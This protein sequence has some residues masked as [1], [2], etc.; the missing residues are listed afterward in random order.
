M[1][2]RLVFALKK[3]SQPKKPRLL[4]VELQIQ[5]RRRCWRKNR[6]KMV[7]KSLP[8]RD[9]SISTTSSRGMKWLLLCVDV[10]DARSPGSSERL[11]LEVVRL[12][13]AGLHG[14]QRVYGRF[15]HF[16]L[17]HL[18]RAQGGELRADMGHRRKQATPNASMCNNE[19]RER[20]GKCAEEDESDPRSAGKK[21]W[22]F[23][24]KRAEKRRRAGKTPELRERDPE[25]WGRSVLSV[26]LCRGCQGW[27]IRQQPSVCAFF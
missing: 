17:H 20:S 13:A 25:D 26:R 8:K 16:D 12:G 9:V 18:L 3:A 15:G 19:K 27:F 14:R 2:K 24:N 7:K 4:C 1:R 21:S 22:R 5:R 10:M 6:K 11:Y 23:A